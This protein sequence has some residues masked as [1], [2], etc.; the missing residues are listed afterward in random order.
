MKEKIHSAFNHIIHRVNIIFL[1][2]SRN[3]GLG[4]KI[5]KYFSLAAGFFFLLFLLFVLF[6]YL[7]FFG[8]LPGK[9]EIS[10]IRNPFASEVYSSDSV[11]MGRYYIQNR[12]D[13]D[14][15]ELTP[16][17][18]NS[19]LSTEDVRFYEHGGI[20]IRSLFRVMF[21]TI[22]LS[23][24]SSGG[25]STIT[26]Q[27]AKNLYPREKH[28]FISMPVNK[29]REMILALRLENIYTKDE[30]LELY[31]NTVPFGEDTYGIKTAST[32]FFNKSPGELKI[33][34]V[35]MLVGMLK[36]T[37]YY[38]P[39]R[40]PERAKIRR[41][42]VLMQ[43]N[44]YGKL[45]QEDTDSLIALPLTLR[46]SSLPYF[47]GIA[48][49]FREFL[50]N[51]LDKRLG[52]I[53]KEDGERYNLYTDGLRIYTSIDSRMQHYARESVNEHLSYLQN[54]FNSEWKNR[55]IWKS[56]NVAGEAYLKGRLNETVLSDTSS[57]KMKVFSWE[58]DSTIRLSS[59]DSVKYF[60]NFLQTGFLV[61]DVNTSEI[62]AWIGGIDFKYFKYDHV[63][64]RRQ[65]GSVFKPL[66]YLAALQNGIDPCG[67]YPNDSIVYSEY[68]DW[69]PQNADRNYG[70]EYSV[71]GALTHS[72]NTIS[73][74][75][76]IETGSDKV[77]NIARKV[78]IESQIPA[79]PSIA[80]GTA[81]LSLFEILRFY[82][83]L[84][85][86]G[87][88]QEP[89]YLKSITDKKGKILFEED[90]KPATERVFT[91]E[92]TE[93]MTAMLE[94]VVNN[95]TAAALRYKYGL[96]NDIA[97]KTGTSQNNSDG[98]FIGYT[99]SLVAGVWV[100]GELPGIRFRSMKYGQGA[101]SAMPVFAKFLQKV[102]NDSVYSGLKYSSF[103]ISDDVKEMLDCEDF[104]EHPTMPEIFRETIIEKLRKWG[105]LKKRKRK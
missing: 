68:E 52:S 44:H 29:L 95:G 63:L 16:I 42:T 58:G 14:D 101:F 30:L 66:V 37:A 6:I 87:L 102:Y 59:A 20:D 70:G 91:Q 28:G 90:N 94:N 10:D 81:N 92:E 5:L 54:I 33:E 97:G 39:R 100:G 71:K 99:P 83:T 38:N 7:G 31:L 80:L 84:A 82:S 24:G 93:I 98:W 26:Q 36:A 17:I 46:Y 53:L 77:I 19:L 3:K 104:R 55:D 35:A 8:P 18:K 75:L 74:A 88:R 2:F 32:L 56:M 12:L 15:D 72:V 11:L 57:R 22:L 4:L 21:K 73:A 34:E 27:L 79:V 43:L 50:R 47:A 89:V 67:F 86:G 96:Y 103:Q 49:Y 60:M 45:S 13:L 85:S 25:G 9:K 23:R 62:K 40:Y 105:F 65:T 41:N 1:R 69:S 61:L 48:P 64:S 51:E 76:I 78:G